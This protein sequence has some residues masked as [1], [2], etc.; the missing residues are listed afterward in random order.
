MDEEA[1]E[2]CKN[3]NYILDV[4]G[5]RWATRIFLRLLYTDKRMGFN[6]LLRATPGINPK[7]LADRL[8]SLESHGLVKREVENS[9]IRSYYSL[10]EAGKDFKGAI[11]MMLE[12]NKK[13]VIGKY[14]KST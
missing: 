5:R 8:K 11:E 10:T 1:Q 3:M 4:L 7:M 13:W 6:E 9:P 2:K 12:W 14:K